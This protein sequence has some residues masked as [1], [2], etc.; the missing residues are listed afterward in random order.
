MVRV[1]HCR[2][3]FGAGDLIRQLNKLVESRVVCDSSPFLIPAMP[4]PGWL[5]CVRWRVAQEL[6]G[7]PG[8]GVA[9]L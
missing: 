2:W 1:V 4:D 8:K 9:G 7:M 5:G 3:K 6:A